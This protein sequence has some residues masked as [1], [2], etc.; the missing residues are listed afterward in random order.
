MSDINSK[1]SALGFNSDDSQKLTTYLQKLYD[2]NRNY[3]NQFYEALSKNDSGKILELT[4][5]APD[6]IK[7]LID[8][9]IDVFSI[10]YDKIGEVLSLFSSTIKKAFTHL[11]ELSD[12]DPEKAKYIIGIGVVSIILAYLLGKKVKQ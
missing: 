1:L 11:A 6:E 3:Y 7:Q 9:K 12:K 2:S 10:L 4:E 8:K 5:N